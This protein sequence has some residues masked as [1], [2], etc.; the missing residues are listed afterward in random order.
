[1]NNI[2]IDLSIEILN[3]SDNRPCIFRNKI[4]NLSKHYFMRCAKNSVETCRSIF[5]LQKGDIFCDLR[6]GKYYKAISDPH[7]NKH[8]KPII[9]C[10]LTKEK[11]YGNH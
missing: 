7:M 2:Y 3:V 11:L 9:N 1:M 6:S 10:I 8:Y 4:S 5:D